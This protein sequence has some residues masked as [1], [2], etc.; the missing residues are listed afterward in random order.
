MT[1]MIS[2]TDLP[3]RSAFSSLRCRSS[4]LS[5]DV[6]VFAI[7]DVDFSTVL[8]E[9]QSETQHFGNFRNIH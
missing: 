2:A 7:S 1:A 3:P 9:F 8:D 5:S 4:D 6:I